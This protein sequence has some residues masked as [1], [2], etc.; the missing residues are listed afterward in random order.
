LLTPG[1]RTPGRYK[2]I[3]YESADWQGYRRGCGDGTVAAPRRPST[4]PP[5][6]SMDGP[7]YIRVCI[8]TVPHTAPQGPAFESQFPLLCEAVRT[9]PCNEGDWI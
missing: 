7:G 2:V 9:V 5:A 3:L 4:T 6:G 8:E 1:G